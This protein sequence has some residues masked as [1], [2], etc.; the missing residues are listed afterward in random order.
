MPRRNIVNAL[1][2]SALY[3]FSHLHDKISYNKEKT[4]MNFWFHKKEAN[5]LTRWATSSSSR[6]ILF[7]KISYLQKKVS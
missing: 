2:K 7:Y 5:I 6:R 1:S 4:K 3:V